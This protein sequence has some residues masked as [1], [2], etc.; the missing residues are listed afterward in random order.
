VTDAAIVFENLAFAYQSNEWICRGYS[1]SV[2]R[3]TVFSI[4]GPNGCGKTTLLKLLLGVLAPQEGVIRHHGQIGF[5]PQIFQVSF[6]YTALEMVLMGRA[7]QIGL[8]AVPSVSDQDAAFEALRKLGIDGLADRGFDELSGGQRQLV[9][10]ARALASEAHTLVLDEPTSALDLRNQGVI[11]E[12]MQRLSREQG[13]TIVFTT[14]HPDHAY[15][16]ADTT[17]LMLGREEF[18]CGPTRTVMTEGSLRRL[19]GADLKQLSFEYGG[20]LIET[21]APVFGIN[22]A[23]GRSG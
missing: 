17:L 9:I 10:F 7:R 11:L 14:H 22:H 2:T 19:Y 6:D 21:F 5:A 23:A 16:V 18:L 20:R 1:G 8:F 15:A 4:L 3:G 13:L 12:W